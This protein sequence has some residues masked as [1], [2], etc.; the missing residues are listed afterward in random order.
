VLLEEI[1]VPGL[2][3]IERDFAPQEMEEADQVF[4]TST[5][6]DLLAVGSVDGLRLQQKPAVFDRLLD[7]F[8]R[9]QNSYIA[10]RTK[11]Q[12]ALR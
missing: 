3:M 11:R 5:T 10:K 8:H 9:Y 7:A 6:R 12:V 1:S 2:D 4:I